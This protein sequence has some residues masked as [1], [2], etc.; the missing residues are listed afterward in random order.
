MLR[1]CLL[2]VVWSVLLACGDA[3]EPG[4]VTVSENDPALDR[5]NEQLSQRPGD[6]GLYFERAGLYEAAGD[7]PSADLDYRRA[8]QLDS[9]RA[10]YGYALASIY[11]DGGRT[12]EALRVLQRID[13]LQPGTPRYQLLLAEAYAERGDTTS[14]IGALNRVVGNDPNVANAYVQLSLLYQFSDP[15]LALTY[16]DTAM[17]LA[18]QDPYPLELRGRYLEQAGRWEAAVATYRRINLID[19]QY[20]NGNRRAGLILLERGRPREAYREFNILVNNDPADVAAYYQRGLASEQ[21]GEPERARRDYET[22]L[23][24]DPQFTEARR[25]LDQLGG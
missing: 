1:L 20:S 7:Y 10:D 15:D 23:R 16:L 2:L 4:V 14:A 25:A 24:M 5:V 21:M 19:R 9:N 22:A 3:G 13:S 6:A 17:A 18:P 11:L 8:Y 12:G